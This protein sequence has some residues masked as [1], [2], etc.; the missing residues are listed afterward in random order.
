MKP[1]F[2]GSTRVN[3]PNDGSILRISR[4]VAVGFI[5]TQ[6]ARSLKRIRTSQRSHSN[7][8]V[9]NDR[10]DSVAFRFEGYT[11]YCIIPGACADFLT[12]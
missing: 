9:P 1:L 2:G 7:V 8:L 4:Q 12:P 5:E 10:R 3:V 6:W 11:Q